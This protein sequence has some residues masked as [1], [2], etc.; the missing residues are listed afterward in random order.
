M[1]YN[2]IIIS[3]Y[4][5][6]NLNKEFQGRTEFEIHPVSGSWDWNNLRHVIEQVC[7]KDEDDAIVVCH[8]GHHF[9]GDY[10]TCSFMGALLESS[11]LGTDMLLGGCRVFGNLVP[12]SNRLYWVNKFE[13][14]NFFV[15]FRRSF[16]PLL[17]ISPN[18][19]ENLDEILSRGLSN[20]LL[21]SP[22]ISSN[23]AKGRADSQLALYKYI[24]YKYQIRR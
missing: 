12:V 13:G 14:S 1:D 2:D 6:G 16:Q 9:T 19:D 17:D 5:V 18:D 21:I 4:L 8:E 3:T 20:K 22:F 7:R 23:G 11:E 15:L 10:Q 24:I